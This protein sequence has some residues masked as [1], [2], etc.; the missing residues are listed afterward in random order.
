MIVSLVVAMSE[1][2]VIGRNGGLPWHLPKDLQ[3]FKKVTLDKTIVM[4][5]KTFDEIKRPLANRRNVVITRNPDFRPPGVTVVPTLQEAL[6]L[7]ATENELCVIGGGEVFRQVL[8]RADRI[9]L[10][11]VHAQIEGDTTF[12]TF[13]QDGWA[14]ESEE[15]HQ[16][17]A[18]HAW[19]FTFRIYNR[20]RTP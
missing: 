17:D 2:R 3:F 14:L 12:P 6:A 16:A 13:E 7:G 4:G 18:K 15:P 20:I 1:N 5:R 10:T 11:L 9:Y 8:P 19:A